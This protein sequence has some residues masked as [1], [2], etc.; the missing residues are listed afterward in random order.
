ML[1]LV[2]GP[3]VEPGVGLVVLGESVPMP[4]AAPPDVPEDEGSGVVP[5][6]VVSG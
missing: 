5:G 6:V 4:P 2:V 1:G 3:G